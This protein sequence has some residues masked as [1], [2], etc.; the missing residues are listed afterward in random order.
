MGGGVHLRQILRSVAE[1]SVPEFHADTSKRQVLR[2]NAADSVRSE[3]NPRAVVAARPR[4]PQKSNAVGRRLVNLRERPRLR[5]AVV[6]PETP[7]GRDVGPKTLFEIDL[8]VHLCRSSRLV[9]V[10]AMNPAV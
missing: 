4:R 2:M 6:P 10:Q 5:L 3:R 1:A 8:I 7:V 9:F